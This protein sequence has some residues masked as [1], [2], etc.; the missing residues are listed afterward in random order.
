MRGIHHKTILD[1]NGSPQGWCNFYARLTNGLGASSED[2]TIASAQQ[3]GSNLTEWVE[4][5]Y[6][7]PLRMVRQLGMASGAGITN[8]LEGTSLVLDWDFPCNVHAS[9]TITNNAYSEHGELTILDPTTGSWAISAI[10]KPGA[11]GQITGTPYFIQYM[12]MAQT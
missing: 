3:A 7:S 12:T 8:G 6:G 10:M 4:D 1:A 5:L 9:K 11:V 2:I